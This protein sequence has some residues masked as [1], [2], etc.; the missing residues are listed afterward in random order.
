MVIH[1]RQVGYPE[2]WGKTT[3][4]Y[5]DILCTTT[6]SLRIKPE[7]DSFRRG[8]ALEITIVHTIQASA[9]KYLQPPLC[10]ALYIATSALWTSPSAS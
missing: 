2:K 5:L 9:N 1:I 6:S 3:S 4:T 7:H 10:L 8:Y